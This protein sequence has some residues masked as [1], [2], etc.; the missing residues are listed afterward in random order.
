MNVVWLAS[1]PKSGNTWLATLLYNYIYKPVDE[2]GEVQNRIPDIHNLAAK[3]ESLNEA[4]DDTI[5]CKTHLML[6]ENH[7]HFTSTVAF[8]YLMRNPKDVLLSSYNFFKLVDPGMQVSERDFAISFIENMGEKGWENAGMGAWPAHAGSWLTH[9]S[10]FPHMFLSY[11]GIKQAPADTLRRILWFLNIEVDE[12]KIAAAV[13]AASFKNMRKMEEKERQAGSANSM[14]PAAADKPAYF[15]NKGK[16][17]Q[18]LTHL[19]EDVEQAFNRR[20][21]ECGG[22][23]GYRFDSD[24]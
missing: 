8:I 18:T 20:F 22:M 6:G 13:E 11:E 14:F 4:L 1:Y 12:Q 17:G 24:S 5:L 23:F 10:R 21:R 2:S 9:A 3:G 19:G 16:S 15:V 7:P